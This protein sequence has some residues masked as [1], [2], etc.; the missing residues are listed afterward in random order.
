MMIS[1]DDKWQVI[2]VWWVTIPE[3]RHRGIG[4]DRAS[5]ATLTPPPPT[6]LGDHYR[7]SQSQKYQRPAWKCVI[8]V[9]LLYLNQWALRFRRNNNHPS[10]LCQKTLEMFK[11]KYSLPA[12]LL[13]KSTFFIFINTLPV[14][15]H[16]SNLPKYYFSLRYL[17]SS[18]FLVFPIHSIHSHFTTIYRLIC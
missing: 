18:R 5:L 14:F 13:A 3:L 9:W 2:S 15:T 8:L 7:F 6:L 11:S 1:N 12:H 17:S 4:E 10:V 16:S